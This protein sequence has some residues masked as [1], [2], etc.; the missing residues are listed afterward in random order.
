MA[1]GNGVEP[2]PSP[3]ATDHGLRSSASIHPSFHR[4]VV[5]LH[6][7]RSRFQNVLIVAS[8]LLIAWSFAYLAAGTGAWSL[9]GYRQ[10]D[11]LM[12]LVRLVA[13]LATAVEASV[14][15]STRIGSPACPMAG[16]SFPFS[17]PSS[18][19]CS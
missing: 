11:T 18:T 17:S 5:L 7:A 2:P 12:S 3:L 1:T 10:S 19:S 6:T 9:F 4:L 16:R 8:T 15:A 13:F 14:R